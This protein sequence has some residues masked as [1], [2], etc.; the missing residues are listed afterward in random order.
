MK[1]IDKLKDEF[2]GLNENM[3]LQFIE[4]ARKEVMKEDEQGLS[5]VSERRRG[6]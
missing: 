2:P 5:N 1:L 4:E 6:N 3:L